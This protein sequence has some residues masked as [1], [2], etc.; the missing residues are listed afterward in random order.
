MAILETH[1]QLDLLLET[2]T[3]ATRPTVRNT[4]M[5]LDLLLET[6]MQLDPLLETHTQLDPL[7][8]THTQ[9]DP[10]L[11]TQTRPDP[12]LET[13]DSYRYY[14]STVSVELYTVCEKQIQL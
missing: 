9:L 10:L 1:K 14:Y 3:Y 5:Q 2:G 12:L 13:H 8:E 7:L 11:E 6:H 4:N